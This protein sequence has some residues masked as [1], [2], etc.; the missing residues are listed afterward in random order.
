MKYLWSLFSQHVPAFLILVWRFTSNISDILRYFCWETMSKTVV[1]DLPQNV[2]S[3]RFVF[4]C[5]D[6]STSKLGTQAQTICQ[7]THRH[8]NAFVL[9]LAPHR[10]QA[11]SWRSLWRGLRQLLLR[12]EDR[13]E[14]GGT[15]GG[16]RIEGGSW[17][18]SLAVAESQRC[19]YHC[20]SLIHH[21]RERL[22]KRGR[23]RDR[24]DNKGENRG[25]EVNTEQTSGFDP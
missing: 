5:K 3:M 6:S 13:G 9:A 1:D 10:F 11:S 8:T 16:Q 2:V 19:A 15:R 14:E 4:V 25:T 18:R 7:N 17:Q 23:N 22:N 20:L 21:D 12:I 24:G